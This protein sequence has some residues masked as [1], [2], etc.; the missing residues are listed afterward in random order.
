L[1]NTVFR[2]VQNT[3]RS[4]GSIDQATERTALNGDLKIDQAEAIA[5]SPALLNRARD[6][7][8]VLGGGGERSEFVPSERLAANI[9]TGFGVETAFYAEPTATISH[10]RRLTDPTTCS[11]E[12]C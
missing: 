9:W 2:R 6:P 4:P 12:P 7:R 3:F 8:R 11:P 10:R 1:T 5:E